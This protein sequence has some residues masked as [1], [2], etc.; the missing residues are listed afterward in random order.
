M[1]LLLDECV[2]RPLKR[3]LIGHDVRHVSEMGWSSKRNG[4]L[5]QLML[6]A[7]FDALL[8]VDQNLE[9]QQNVRASG[10]GVIVL[11]ARTNRL[12]ELRP[13]VPQILTALERLNPGE[14][15]RVPA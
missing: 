9:F 2:P 14:L 6:A 3:D 13:L 15:I 4:E 1:L 11:F 7:Q 12:P 10:V 5:L 8:T